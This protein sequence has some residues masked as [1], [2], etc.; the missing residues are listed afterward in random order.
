MFNLRRLVASLALFAALAI[1]FT[2]APV[3]AL[4]ISLDGALRLNAGTGTAVSNAVTL[5]NKAGVI[6]T[7]ALTT[8]AAATYTLTIT[9]TVVA[10]ADL[11]F[12]SVAFGTSTTGVPVLSRMTPAAGSLVLIVQN[13]HASAAFN[14]TLVI[15]FACF[16]A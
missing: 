11:C 7:E 6:T 4:D 16:K 2:P 5:A 12:G 1:A 9:D 3:R 13:N 14:G 10:A 15:T 8:A